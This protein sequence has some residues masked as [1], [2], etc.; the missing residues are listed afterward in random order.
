MKCIRHTPQ[1]NT[2]YALDSLI[3]PHISPLTTDQD[4]R[5]HTAN[6]QI[7]ILLQTSHIPGPSLGARPQPTH[8]APQTPDTPFDIDTSLPHSKTPIRYTHH[9]YQETEE[10][11]PQSPINL[12]TATKPPTYPT[13]PQPKA[14]QPPP[15]YLPEE[16]PP[17]PHPSPESEDRHPNTSPKTEPKHY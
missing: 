5:H 6:T 9:T 4:W 1:D 10:P 15:L 3:H 8:P 2:W 12:T 14:P 16:A 13:E 11:P 7:F 17:T